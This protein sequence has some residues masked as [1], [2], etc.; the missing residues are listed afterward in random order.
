[1]TSLA[2]AEAVL[3]ELK[4]IPDEFERLYGINTQ[5]VEPP[6]PKTIR[7]QP[8]PDREPNG[9]RQFPLS[10]LVGALTTNPQTYAEV[11]AKL[12]RTPKQIREK[13][14]RLYRAAG[15]N[16]Y[17]F[18]RERVGTDDYTLRLRAAGP[19]S[20]T[21]SKEDPEEAADFTGVTAP[22]SSPEKVSVNKW[23]D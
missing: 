10:E 20:E 23:V 14:N 4:A 15:P 17:P 12:D 22:P 13:V 3:D 11:G 18:V 6:R 19:T 1:V 2:E 21:S 9:Y 16:S 8:L 5:W 7:P